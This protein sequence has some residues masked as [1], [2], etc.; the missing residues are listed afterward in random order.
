MRRGKRAEREEGGWRTFGW[1]S[2]VFGRASLRVEDVEMDE[3]TDHRELVIELVLVLEV[4]LGLAD[5]TG[6]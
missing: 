2:G 1:I 6:D 4:V 3:A 5:D